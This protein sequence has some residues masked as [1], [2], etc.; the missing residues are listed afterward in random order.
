M[1]K[2]FKERNPDVD[3]DEIQN[4]PNVPDDVKAA[5]SGA[6]TL[7][8]DDELESSDGEQNNACA[9][10]LKIDAS[11]LESY[12]NDFHMDASE[13]EFDTK[14]RRRRNHENDEDWCAT[15]KDRTKR[16]KKRKKR[17]TKL[18]KKPK[19][20]KIVLSESNGKGTKNRTQ[21]KTGKK[22]STSSDNKS[23]CYTSVTIDQMDTQNL[24]DSHT[25]IDGQCEIDPLIAINSEVNADAVVKLENLNT[26][27]EIGTIIDK[28]KNMGKR[29]PGRKRLS[30]D[31]ER[32][33]KVKTKVKKVSTIESIVASIE[34]VVQGHDEANSVRVEDKVCIKSN[35]SSLKVNASVNETKSRPLPT[36][37][38]IN[39]Q[40]K[41]SAVNSNTS[42]ATV[43]QGN[44]HSGTKQF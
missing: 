42:M 15:P 3:M 31:K 10:T 14:K 6:L 4:N 26:V 5:I 19:E 32:I 22:V 34:S 1:K 11:F 30:S 7:T 39:K 33:P 28:S 25:K 41:K 40:N 16:G 8:A 20:K 44:N 18:P 35:P 23:E 24:Y 29:K 36:V 37:T 9:G 38:K 43:L 13:D 21:N 27:N 12:D 17:K 2:S